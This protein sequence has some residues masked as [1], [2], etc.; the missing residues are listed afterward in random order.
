MFPEL[1]AKEVDYT[2]EVLREWDGKF[3]W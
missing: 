3:G 2:I 1:T